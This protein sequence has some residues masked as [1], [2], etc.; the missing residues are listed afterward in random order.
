MRGRTRGSGLFAGLGRGGFV[1]LLVYA[2]FGHELMKL[3]GGDPGGLSGNVYFSLVTGQKPFQ[4]FTFGNFYGRFS[5]FR[6]G[7][8]RIGVQGGEEVAVFEEFPRKALR[9]ED[10]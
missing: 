6:Q 8:F 2:V 10:C 7:E 9:T 3:A 5:D 1:V 4:I